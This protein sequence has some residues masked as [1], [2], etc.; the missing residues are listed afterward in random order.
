MTSIT[1]I[2]FSMRLDI[3][4]VPYEFTNV[5]ELEHLSKDEAVL[6]LKHLLFV[7]WPQLHFEASKV[8]RLQETIKN[9]TEEKD[10]LFKKA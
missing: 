4:G 9:L 10:F 8:S 2:R 3:G 6:I 1:N 5:N 7:E